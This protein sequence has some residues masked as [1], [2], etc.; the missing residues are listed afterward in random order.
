[1]ATY[2]TS[3]SGNAKVSHIGTEHRTAC[4]TVFTSAYHVTTEPSRPVC[5]ACL[6]RTKEPLPADA[7]A[8]PTTQDERDAIVVALLIAGADNMGVARRLHIG[9]RTAVR[10]I[11]AAQDRAGAK[12]RFQWG[13]KVGRAEERP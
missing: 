10:W 7:V 1:M 12:T 9:L 6:T 5:A 13:H 2:V 8:E 11:N 4:G 3:L